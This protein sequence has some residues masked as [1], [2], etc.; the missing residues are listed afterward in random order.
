MFK[1]IPKLSW[2]QHGYMRTS[3]GQV[4]WL[5]LLGNTCSNNCDVTVRFATLNS[6]HTLSQ[7]RQQNIHY[8]SWETDKKS[9][10]MFSLDDILK[11]Q[12]IN[13]VT[14]TGGATPQ[15]QLEFLLFPVVQASNL[16]FNKTTYQSSTIA[17][18]QN[19]TASKVVDG[20]KDTYFNQ[21]SCSHTRPEYEPFWV[22]NLGQVYRISYVAITNRN[23]ARYCTLYHIKF[24]A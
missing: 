15:F 6:C 12:V 8:Y 21:G 24:S 11:I 23:C 1:I 3:W 19:P 13:V 22:V 9:I 4:T 2:L 18:T 20:N 10:K 17:N 14:F 16:A 7:N 5:F